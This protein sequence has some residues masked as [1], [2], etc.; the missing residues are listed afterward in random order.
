[1]TPRF[2][3]ATVLVALSWISMTDAFA[4]AT[5]FGASDSALVKGMNFGILTLLLVVL[6]VLGGIASFFVYLIRRSAAL[7]RPLTAET[8]TVSNLNAR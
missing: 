3:R 7:E 2:Y 8:A 4:C 5:C 6:G 1:M